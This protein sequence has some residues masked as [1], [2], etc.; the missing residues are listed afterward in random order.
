MENDQ[1]IA[2]ETFCTYYNVEY[3]FVESLQHNDLIETVF[4][5]ESQFI[6]LP[7]LQKIE[8]MVRLHHDLDI[9]PEGL[10]AIHTLLDRI[11]SLDREIV[12]LRNKLRFYEAPQ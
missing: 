2:V 10:G 6:Q 12:L 3:S 7:Q 5:N 1:L 8:R 9:N 11:D 4:V